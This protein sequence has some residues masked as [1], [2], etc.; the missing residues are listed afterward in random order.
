MENKDE[1][2]GICGRSRLPQPRVI[3]PPPQALSKTRKD[4]L[5]A[6]EAVGTAISD[7]AMR[8]RF[9]WK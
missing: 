7:L 5:E 1:V 2:C 9:R 4:A 8:R 6:G 3:L